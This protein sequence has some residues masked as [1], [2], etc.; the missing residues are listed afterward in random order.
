MR[1]LAIDA[2]V[3]SCSA[4]FGEEGGETRAVHDDAPLNTQAERV[5]PLIE[6]LLV[7]AGTDYSEIDLLAVTI[8]PGS[9]TACRTAVAAVRAMA[10]ATGRPIMAANGLELAAEAARTETDGGR[11]IVAVHDARRGEVMI[12]TFDRDGAAVN[13]PVLVDLER[14]ADRI[15]PGAVLAGNGAALLQT[16]KA[17]AHDV[18]AAGGRSGDARELVARVRRRLAWGEQPIE[19]T[20]LRPLYVRPPDAKPAPVPRLMPE[21]VD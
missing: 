1:I 9:F 19:G 20:A 17:G 12:Q 8:G 6:R 18:T 5:I 13:E 11:S 15:P 7:E 10:L 4:A 3:G 2:V 14:A 16:P 21:P